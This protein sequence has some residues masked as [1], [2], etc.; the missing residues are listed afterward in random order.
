[1]RWRRKDRSPSIKELEN[2]KVQE[3]KAI[4]MAGVCSFTRWSLSWASVTQ[5]PLH[6]TWILDPVF[7]AER[8][9][10]KTS[11]STWQ[12]TGVQHIQHSRDYIRLHFCQYAGDSRNKDRD[13]RETSREGQ[14]EER[15]RCKNRGRYGFP[16]EFESCSQGGSLSTV[17]S[18]DLPSFQEQALK[19]TPISHAACVSRAS[20]VCGSCWDHDCYYLL[21]F[22][23]SHKYMF[24]NPLPCSW[25]HW[26]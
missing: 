12:I 1:M 14:G 17:E 5:G 6:Y 21:L 9:N 7:A 25:T 19:I 11:S 3:R 8:E 13:S 23:S 2:V 15:N 22:L 16:S 18:T 24:L 26:G 10:L 20:V 4:F